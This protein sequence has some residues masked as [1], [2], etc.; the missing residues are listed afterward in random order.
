MLSYSMLNLNFDYSSCVKVSERVN[1]RVDEV[2]PQ[3]TR[4]D[5]TRLFLPEQLART[6]GLSALAGEPFLNDIERRSLNQ[7]S[8]NA[9][10]NLFSFVEEY[11]LATMLKHAQAEVF[12]DPSAL[13]ALTR[14]VDEELKHQALFDRYKQAFQRDFGHPC[15]VL[16]TAQE[17]AGVIMSHSPMAVLLITLHIELMTQQHFTECVKDADVDPLFKS[18][19]KHHWL[20]EAQHARIDALELDKLASVAT[21]A[22]I[23]LA[24]DEY[25]GILEAFDGLLKQQAE[26]DVRTLAEATKRTFSDRQAAAI[27]ATQ[28]ENYR[29]TFIWYGMTNAT[30]LAHLSAMTKAKAQVVSQAALRFDRVE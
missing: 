28:L 5:F 23:E 1:W 21:P 20:E 4:L 25:L 22:A 14:F 19:L 15:S 2:M 26:L 30:F 16:E 17:V 3:E 13:R 9:Y 6:R 27:Q 7:I 8:G 18:L 24:A 11:I 10:L 12:G 29:K